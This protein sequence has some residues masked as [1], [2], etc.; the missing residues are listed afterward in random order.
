MHPAA[1]VIVFTTLSGAGYG[2]LALL[3]VMAPMGWLPADRLLGLSGSGLALIFISAGLA[4]STFHLRHPERAWRA[5]SQWRS[6]WLSREGVV[7]LATYPPALAFAAGW[8]GLGRTDG[9]WAAMGGLAALGAA[10]TVFCTAMIYASLR[11]IAAWRDPLVVPVYLAFAAATGALW[12]FAAVR[13]TGIEAGPAITTVAAATAALAWCLKLVYWRRLSGGAIGS[14]SG[15]TAE[16][17]TGL[18]RFGTVRSLDPPHTGEDYVRREMGFRVA[19]KHAG[20]L[21]RLAFL[22]GLALPLA[23]LA[24]DL[25]LY[26]IGAALAAVLAALAASLGVLIERWLFFAEARH[27]AALYYGDR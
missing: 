11:P 16:S 18:G 23:I 8:A 7:A 20:K 10:A 19:R 12:L 3:G 25:V 1:S 24:L 27:T 5:L 13:V 26:G 6:S 22:F 2:L 9:V 21:R 17:A 14:A 4:A 15:A